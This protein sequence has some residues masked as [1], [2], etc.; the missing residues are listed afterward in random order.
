MARTSLHFSE[1]FTC[2]VSWSL[3]SSKTAFLYQ[4]PS[5]YTLHFI[6]NSLWSII[7]SSAPFHPTWTVQL[8][9]VLDQDSWTRQRKTV[10]CLFPQM[11]TACNACSTFLYT[12]VSFLA[13]NGRKQCSYIF[14]IPQYLCSQKFLPINIYYISEVNKKFSE[15]LIYPAQH[16]SVL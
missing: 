7:T 5:Y 3:T 8:A 6:N 13:L 15:C 9:I 1:L 4:L 14:L 12:Q 11:T 10:L 16:I 2:R